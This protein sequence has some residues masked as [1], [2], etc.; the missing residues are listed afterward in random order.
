MLCNTSSLSNLQPNRICDFAT[1]E[2]LTFGSTLS[3]VGLHCD[4]RVQ[5]I[6]CAVGFLTTI[7][8]TLVHSLNLLVAA[9][10]A[11]VLLST[12]DGDEGV[13]LGKRVRILH[14]I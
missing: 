3:P 2:R 9:T 12:R 8:P 14:M 10:G 11:L 4:M 5:V 1:N 13:D 7:P 6:E